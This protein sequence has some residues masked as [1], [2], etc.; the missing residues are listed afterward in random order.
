MG[1]GWKTQVDEFVGQVVENFWQ[2]RFSLGSSPQN[3]V[4]SGFGCWGQALPV[5]KGGLKWHAFVVPDRAERPL[6]EWRGGG[7]LHQR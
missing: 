7:K 1:F 3:W 6:K 4:R 5:T 2:G